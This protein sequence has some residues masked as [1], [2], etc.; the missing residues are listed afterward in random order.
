MKRV[1]E[2]RTKIP[3]WSVLEKQD[4][5]IWEVRTE[6]PRLLPDQT[7]LKGSDSTQ[8]YSVWSARLEKTFFQQ[9]VCSGTYYFSS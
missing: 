6:A 2:L 9:Y 3:D 4:L 8:G 5:R 7:T 1:G